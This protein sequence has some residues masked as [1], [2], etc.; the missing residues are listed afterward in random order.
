MSNANDRGRASRAA[1]DYSEALSGARRI[2]N[3]WYRSQ[4][5]TA[6]ARHAPE[7][8]LP[9]LCKEA[10]AAARECKDAYRQVSVVAWIARALIERGATEL[11]K[12]HLL[13]VL[14]N[15]PNI[16]PPP[17]QV[18][19]LFS[20][21]NAIRVVS[22]L[23]QPVFALLLRACETANSWRAGRAMREIVQTIAGG[24]P[25][26]AEEVWSWMPETRYK[27]QARRRLDAG[28]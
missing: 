17:S 23:R 15:V 11:L 6:V 19:A 14:A 22:S 9:T 26:L 3:P 18:E 27:R 16:T 8:A 21:W 24:D 7:G 28:G 1:I 13:T 12:P 20:L 10:F 2:Q 5:L 25:A 4:A